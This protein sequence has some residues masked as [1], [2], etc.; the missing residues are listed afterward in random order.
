ML[1]LRAEFNLLP[2]SL[3][4]K[5]HPG[6]TISIG[7]TMRMR[8]YRIYMMRAKDGCAAYHKGQQRALPWVPNCEEGKTMGCSVSEEEEFC[9][10]YNGTEIDDVVWM[11]LPTDKLLWGFIVL[12]EGGIRLRCCHSK[13]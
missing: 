7:Y 13:G 11:G 9:L 6:C 4:K 10:I 8:V 3:L 12:L 5:V 2:S 1:S